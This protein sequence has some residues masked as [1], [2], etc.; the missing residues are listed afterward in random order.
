MCEVEQ[1]DCEGSHNYRD[2]VRLPIQEV[3]HYGTG[4]SSKEEVC[5]QKADFH[6]RNHTR[7]YIQVDVNVKR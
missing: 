4:K 3:K 7:I 6:R 2:R 5:A 1:Q